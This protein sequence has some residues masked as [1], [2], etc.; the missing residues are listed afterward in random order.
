MSRNVKPQNARTS[1]DNNRPAAHLPTTTPARRSMAA[2]YITKY[3]AQDKTGAMR[4]AF[5]NNQLVKVIEWGQKA[6]AALERLMAPSPEELALRDRAVREAAEKVEADEAAR[7]E[8]LKQAQRDEVAAAAA[9]A[10]EKE[11]AE[12]L[13]RAEG[14]AGAE[15]LTATKL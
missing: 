11:D 5:D 12:T 10:K 3:S 6:D 8:A 1:S 14:E 15:G 9:A 4:E 2:A 7:A 13:A